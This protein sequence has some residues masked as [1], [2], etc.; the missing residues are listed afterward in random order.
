LISIQLVSYVLRGPTLTE[1]SSSLTANQR[2]DNEAT[3]PAQPG[4]LVQLLRTDKQD[5]ELGAA[6]HRPPTPAQKPLWPGPAQHRGSEMHKQ[7]P[8]NRQ[9]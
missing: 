5:L 6:K 9:T 7:T 4:Q 8:T 2:L 1:S 3:G